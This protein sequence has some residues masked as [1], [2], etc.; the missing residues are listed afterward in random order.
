MDI[1]ALDP[2]PAVLT[3]AGPHPKFA[4]KLNLYGQ[5]VGVWDVDNRYYDETEDRWREGTVVWTFGWILD[6]LGVQDVMRFTLDD[7]ST[8]TGTTVR[9]Y[10][11]GDDLWQVVWFSPSGRLCRLT[12]RPSEDGIFQEGTQPDGR[13]IR[14]I[15]TELTGD[16][17]LWQG[18]V[19][20]A[21]GGS[22]QLEQEMRARR[23][24]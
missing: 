21:G 23:R 18:Y 9:M 12:G 4:D 10:V 20:D 11:P 19:T 5:L 8:P 7:G 14:W 6:G 24:K 15:F 1:T 16:S 2:M 22:W 3:A 17:F 13:R